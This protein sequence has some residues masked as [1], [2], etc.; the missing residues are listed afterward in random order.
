VAD[1]VVQVTPVDTVD[2]ENFK[3]RYPKTAARLRVLKESEKM[4]CV[5]VAYHPGKVDDETLKKVRTGM[6]GAKST[7]RG[8]DLLELCRLTAFEAVPADHDQQLA[9]TLKTYPPPK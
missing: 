7:Q 4:P 9:E 5:V 3:K 2:L 8:R 1:N 6:I